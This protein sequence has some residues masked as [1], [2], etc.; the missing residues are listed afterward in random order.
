M[1]EH[2]QSIKDIEC[3]TLVAIGGGS[4]I[5]VA[6]AISVSPNS[7]EDG[8][9]DILL[10]TKDGLKKR[11]NVIAIPTTAGT[12]AEVTPFATIWDEKNKKKLSLQSP[13]IYPKYAIIDAQLALTL[14][15]E[16]T[17]YSGLDALSHCFE[18]LWNKNANPYSKSLAFSAINIIL[19]TLAELLNNLE[20]LELRKKMAWASMLGGLCINQT[21]TA[22]AHSMSYPLTSHLNI[23]H[24]L[25]SGGFLPEILKFNLENDKS[26]TMMEIQ[27]TLSIY[28][29]LKN[30]LENLYNQIIEMGLLDSIFQNETKI[31]S[32]KNEM[33]HPERSLNNIVNGTS[34]DIQSILVSF[35]NKK[36]N[37]KSELT[38]NN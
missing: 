36:R 24:G 15:V 28:H 11:F 9:M 10:N 22:L 20:N 23:P 34:E 33:I 17:A 29:P 32:L 38:S 18:S 35:Y 16:M 2:I 12:G 4:V 27:Q 26:D 7:S 25:A 8:I 3:D 31:Y 19:D 5:D 30:R 14:G 6:K 21:K 13:N 37:R 1:S